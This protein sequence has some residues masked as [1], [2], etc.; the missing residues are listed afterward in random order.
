MRL[1]HYTNLKKNPKGE[2]AKLAQFL[3]LPVTDEELDLVVHNTTIDYMREHSE[4][5]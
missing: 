1:V 4:K 5:V 3:E 2:I